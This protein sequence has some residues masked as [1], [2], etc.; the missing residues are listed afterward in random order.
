MKKARPFYRSRSSLT[1]LVFAVAFATGCS[2]GKKQDNQPK[3]AENIP[4]PV[5]LAS[6]TPSPADPNGPSIA[7]AAA[8]AAAAPAPAPAPVPVPGSNP[9]PIPSV[10]PQ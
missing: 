3:I 2:S 9:I 1:T 7:A 5:A 4:I 8:A 10:I 6:F